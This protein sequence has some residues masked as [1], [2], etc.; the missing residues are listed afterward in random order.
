MIQT[1][2]YDGWEISLATQNGGCILHCRYKGR[3]ILR[4][5]VR[6]NEADFDPL[7]TGGFC[8]VPFSNRI[9]NGRFTYGNHA[10][11]LSQTHKAIAHPIHG[12]GW[13]ATWD[14]TGKTV[15]SVTLRHSYDAGEWP[16]SYVSDQTF[17]IDGNTLRHS[18]SVTNCSDTVM[19]AGLGFHPYFPDIETAHLTCTT[20]TVWHTDEDGLPVRETAILENWDFSKGRAVKDCGLDNV[21]T[22]AGN[23][24]RIDAATG[25]PPVIIEASDTLPFSVIF[26][27]A[28][29]GSFCYEP[30]SHVTDAVNQADDP[31]TGLTHLPPEQSLRV[32]MRYRIGSAASVE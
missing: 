14:V 28:Q 12:F 3:D 30:I 19:P 10:V 6:G 4:P 25:T 11:K 5:Y 20:D 16:W 24:A 7:R 21:F 27:G 1:L 13:M 18:L 31:N 8:L 32:E 29:D 22:G 23:M 26:T 17:T 15:N 2:N 9:K